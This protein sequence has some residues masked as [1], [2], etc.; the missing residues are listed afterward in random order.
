MFF[1]NIH[2][3]MLFLFFRKNLFWKSFLNGIILWAYRYSKTN[4]LV[5]KLIFQC[6]KFRVSFP[7]SKVS[8]A[9]WSTIWSPRPRGSHYRLPVGCGDV[10]LEACPTSAGCVWG[11]WHIRPS[12]CSSPSCGCPACPAPV[13]FLLPSCP[14]APLSNALTI[15]LSVMTP[16][17]CVKVA[18]N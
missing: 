1:F 11:I 7:Y 2:R 12:G 17:Y 14:F 13:M 5:S 8:Q 4:V 10:M 9:R 3:Y 6:F 16:Y 18:Y 15:S